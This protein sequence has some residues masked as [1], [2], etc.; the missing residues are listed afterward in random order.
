MNDVEEK[1]PVST[2]DDYLIIVNATGL[3]R[4]QYQVLSDTFCNIDILN[5]PFD[6]QECSILIRSSSR[7]KDML[8]IKQRNTKV[9]YMQNIKME[10][11]VFTFF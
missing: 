2:R 7:D 4:W 11:L 8:H 6:E 9:K 5:F 1:K 10:W 3:V